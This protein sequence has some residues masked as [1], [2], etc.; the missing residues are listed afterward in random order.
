MAGSTRRRMVSLPVRGTR[1]WLKDHQIF[2]AQ[3]G[4]LTNVAANRYNL[5]SPP[6]LVMSIPR[7]GSS[8]VGETLGLAPNG[9]YLREPVTQSFQAHGGKGTVV[10]VDPNEPLP[11]CK[12]AADLAFRGIPAFSERIVISGEQWTL[13]S[14]NGRHLV[15]KE[16]NPLALEWY[17][18]EYH[19]RVIYLVR[20]PAAVAL[21]YNRLKWWDVPEE[22]F[23]TRHGEFQARIQSSSYRLLKDYPDRLIV[24]YE[25]LCIDPFGFF[26][27]LFKFAGL[28]WDSETEQYIEEHTS[29][30]DCSDPSG[31]YRQSRNMI[32][33]WVGKISPEYLAQLREAYQASDAPWYKD[34]EDWEKPVKVEPATSAT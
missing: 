12:K 21:S 22:K 16:V 8:W 11:V 13:S 15:I 14:R 34:A 27:D 3:F 32:N 25:K 18:K 6:V 5:Y 26:C 33:S 28:E 31:T 9:L 10:A 23:W 4:P 29:T 24:S 17:L 19:P 7:S 20:H 30:E 2:W 1:Q